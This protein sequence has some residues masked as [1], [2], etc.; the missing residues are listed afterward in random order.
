MSCWY[1][2]CV[3]KDNLLFDDQSKF[4]FISDIFLNEVEN[5]FSECVSSKLYNAGGGCGIHGIN[6]LYV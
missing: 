3:S 5:T 4:F 6:T 1:Y 2:D